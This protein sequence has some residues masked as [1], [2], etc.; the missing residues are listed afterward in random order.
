MA[1]KLPGG[2]LSGDELQFVLGPENLGSALTGATEEVSSGLG[3][4]TEAVRAERARPLDIAAE[5]EE[6]SWTSVLAAGAQETTTGRIVSAIQNSIDDYSRDYDPAFQATSHLDKVVAEYGLQLDENGI[7][8]LLGT[9]TADEMHQR[10]QRLQQHQS[11][12]DI[13]SRHGGTRMLTEMLDPGMLVVDIAT[14][15]MGRVARLGRLASAGTTGAATA[16][17][18]GVGEAV[19]RETDAM[20]YLIAGAL[21]AGVGALWGGEAANRMAA[22]QGDWFGRPRSKL[23]DSVRAFTSETDRLMHNEQSRNL[24]SNIMDDPVRREGW[25]TNDNA[26]SLARVYRN[27]LDGLNKTY[28]DALQ[29]ELKR[30]GFGW[31]SRNF[32]VSGKALQARDVLERKVQQ[33]LAER[34]IYFQRFGTQKPAMV[35]GSVQ[36][37]ADTYTR[38]MERTAQIGKDAGLRGFD[39][40]TSTS[41]Y[42]HRA[43]NPGQIARVEATHGRQFAK[44][45]LTMS[46]MRGMRGIDAEEAELIATAI[47]DRARARLRD[48]TSD[49]IGTLG[50]ADT[51]SLRAMLEASPGVSK[52]RVDSIMARVE[53]RTDEAGVIK[54]AKG[55][56]PLDM[57]ARMTAPDGSSVSVLDLIDNDLGRLAENYTNAVSGRAAL[58]KNGWGG[59]DASLEALRRQ[60]AETLVDLP[61]QERSS[62]LES[63]DGLMGD[64]TGMRPAGHTLGVAAQRI[65]S[66]ADATMLAASGLWQAIDYM[67]MAHRYGTVRAAGEFMRQFPGAAGILRKAGRDPDLSDELRTVLGLDLARDVRIRPWL[68]QHEAHLAASDTAFDRVLHMGKQLVPVLNGMKFVHQHQTRMNANLAVNTLA[69]ASKGDK[70]SLRMLE[71]YGLRGADWDRVRNAINQNARFSGKNADE[72]NWSAWRQADID[73]A[74]ATVTRMMDDAIIYGRIGQGAG[75]PLIARTQIGQVLG[76]FRSFVS[77]AHNKLLRGTLHNQGVVGLATLLAMQYPLTGMMVGLNEVRKGNPVD[78]SEEGLQDIAAK[79]LGYTAG[80]GFVGDAL[81]IIGVGGRGGLSTPITGVFDSATRL[82]GGA[83]ALIEGDVRGGAADIVQSAAMVTP[84]VMIMPGTALALKAMRGEE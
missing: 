76:Q 6:R 59:D 4:F 23:G 37:L 5:D 17:Y 12:L 21:G 45:L 75:S 11:N 67:T 66:I 3:S 56:I 69:R 84:A 19:G 32:D 49:F 24:L 73:T 22:G 60:Y 13:L 47:L 15:G 29:D 54:Y 51:E 20:D 34:D 72:L 78:F 35:H 68:R 43:W 9:G 46:A 58:A 71:A 30:M 63:F 2:G 26:A 74:M 82:A 44:D 41:G 81:G 57:T 7:E 50:K 31:V 36:R 83:G 33:E 10:A 38:I 42:F 39:D 70:R 18:V 14:L 48:E 28:T 8:F 25:F 52:A 55:R 62:L 27:E 16:G 53:Q 80:L 77:F 65:K 61:A 79:A 1:R 64:F 40:I